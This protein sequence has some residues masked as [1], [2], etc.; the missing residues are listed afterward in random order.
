MF[1][2]EYPPRIVG[3][4]SRHVEGLSRSLVR[5]GNDVHVITTDLP[6]YPME[7]FDQGVKVH[8]V[9]VEAATPSFHSW[10]LMMNHFFEK[11]AAILRREIDS[12]FDVVH[13]H[14]WLVATSSIESKHSFG[15]PLITTL[16]SLEYKRA[17]S[18]SSPESAM[19]DSLE[20]WT[21]YESSLMVVCSGAM[22]TDVSLHFKVPEAKI[23]VIPNAIDPSK[24]DVFVDRNVIRAKYGVYPNEKLVMFVGRLTP[25]KGCEYLIRA[26]PNVSQAH[27]IKVVIVGDGYSR[28]FLENEAIATGQS[29]RFKFVGFIPDGDVVQLLKSC[30]VLV[31][32]SVYEPFG[33]VALEG[34]AAGAP[35]VASDVDGLAEVVKHEQNGILTFAR[36]PLSIA[37]GIDRIL[38]DEEN[39]KRLV[40]NGRKTVY[41]KYS[42]DAVAKLT[43]EAYSKLVT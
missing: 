32:P 9:P 13:A 2:W 21:T 6:G 25:Q 19:I 20:W 5:L 27:N 12:R 10:I 16:H 30:D 42:W 26:V 29:W 4:I 28:G 23:W 22:K 14:D 31:I 17:G 7:D 24:F 40:E 11:R 43:Q 35:I 1:S 18:I 33:V 39:A 34:M 8:R 38:S 3:G 37:W 41:A 36:D 15:S